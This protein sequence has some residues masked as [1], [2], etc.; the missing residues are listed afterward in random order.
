MSG[1]DFR[2]THEDPFRHLSSLANLYL[3]SNEIQYLPDNA[4]QN[5]SSLATLYAQSLVNVND[6]WMNF[7]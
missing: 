4:F 1:N 7:S 2:F 6:F 3:G 5:C